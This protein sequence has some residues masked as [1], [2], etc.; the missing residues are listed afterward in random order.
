MKLCKKCLL[1]TGQIIDRG[2]DGIYTSLKAF[3]KAIEH[4]YSVEPYYSEAGEN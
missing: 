2:L 1:G 4:A 3:L